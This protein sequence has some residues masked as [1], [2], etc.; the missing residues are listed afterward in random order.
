V[1]SA[2][3]EGLARPIARGGL[4]FFPKDVAWAA[5]ANGAG[6]AI[7]VKRTGPV[8]R[9]VR[10]VPGTGWRKP[11]AWRQKWPSATT[12]QRASLRAPVPSA[13]G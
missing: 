11:L 9:A 13:G 7:A 10:K 8:W 5:F 6:F 3:P 12:C 2:L 1:L 4:K